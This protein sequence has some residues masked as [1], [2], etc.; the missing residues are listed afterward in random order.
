MIKIETHPTESPLTGHGDANDTSDGNSNKSIT[1][2]RTLL[3]TC[4]RKRLKKMD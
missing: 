2:M 1:F 3:Y 4:L